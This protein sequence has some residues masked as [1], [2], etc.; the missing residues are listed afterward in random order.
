[1]PATLT[2]CP[3]ISQTRT[4]CPHTYGVRVCPCAAVA[5]EPCRPTACISLAHPP[6]DPCPLTPVRWIFTF[7][8]KE[9]DSE[10]GLSY[11][12]SRYYSSDLS[13]WLSVDPMSGKYPSLSPYVY[14]A[15]NP[16]K[17]V[18]PNGEDVLL[19]G[20]HAKTAFHNMQ[21]GT[22]LKLTMG[23]FGK[24]TAEGEA[25]S[26]ADELL[27]KAINSKSVCAIVLCGDKGNAGSYMGTTYNK[28]NGTAVSVNSV[29]VQAMQKL[30][31]ENNAPTGSGMIH[32][33]TEGYMA[34]EIAISTRHNIREASLH[35][36]EPPETT[37]L[38]NMQF[39]INVVDLWTADYPR[40][41]KKYLQAHN[42][43]SLAPNEMSPSQKLNYKSP[44]ARYIFNKIF[45][46]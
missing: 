22:N 46:R 3:L 16:V 19:I 7:S 36:V 9:K 41:Y 35:P 31:K 13:I 34:G 26:E 18:D 43:A 6:A 5:T 1:M 39:K 11:F 33:A 28:K 25:I 23:R 45:A 40:D 10:T 2:Y 8:A 29:N 14:C 38:N 12:G 24:I 32:E 21:Q 17:L 15:D 4:K 44:S 42:N 37:G 27:L 20:K 30:E